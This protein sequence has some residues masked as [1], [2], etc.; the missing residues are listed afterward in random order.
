QIASLDA[1]C[2]DLK[3]LRDSDKTFQAQKEQVPGMVNDPKKQ[4]SAL[5]EAKDKK[6]AINPQDYGVKVESLEVFKGLLLKLNLDVNQI[7]RA[8]PEIGKPQAGGEK[9]A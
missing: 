1:M 4:Q 7:A 5:K 8:Q 6:G 9:I 3:P 2:A